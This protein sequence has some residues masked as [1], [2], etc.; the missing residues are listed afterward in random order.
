MK[1]SDLKA[2]MA[3]VSIKAK[4]VELKEPREIMTKFGSAT[5][6]TEAMLEDDTGS[7]KLTL[8]GKQADGIE[9]NKEVEIENG[10]IKE[11]REELQITLGR[12]GTI[13][14]VQ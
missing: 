6:L 9:A 11:F 7:I 1:I 14:V 2:G 3:D 10:F 8:W 13:K 12:K 4:I 5:T